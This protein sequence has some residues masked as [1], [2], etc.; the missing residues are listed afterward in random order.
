MYTICGRVTD[1]VYRAFQIVT[2]MKYGQDESSISRALQEAIVLWVK[3]NAGDVPIL[4]TMETMPR[5]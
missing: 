2:K 5:N 3:K 4:E 1:R